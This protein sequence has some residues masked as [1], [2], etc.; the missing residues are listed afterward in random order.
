MSTEPLIRK[1]TH[2]FT[3]LVASQVCVAGL[4]EEVEKYYLA[5]KQEVA[6]AFKYGF[7]LPGTIP[8]P[9][10]PVEITGY[11]IE[12]TDC[13]AWLGHA[14]Q[15]T[16]KYLGMTVNLREMFALP[17]RLPW[18]HILPIFDPAGLTNWQMVEV[19]KAQNLIVWGGTDVGESTGA[20]AEGTTLSL[21]ERSPT[22]TPATM[23]LPPKYARH[24]F[25]GR[26][27]RPL[28]LRGYG[29]GQGLLYEVEKQFLDP[30]VTATVFPEN[31]FPVGGRVACGS[32]HAGDS[33][34]FF[35]RYDDDNEC[36]HCGFR[37]A[38]V[39]EEKRG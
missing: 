33:W 14:E 9:A 21:M 22:P 3:L 18:K 30:G 13:F 37:E 8:I 36:A 16:E 32:W 31:T 15:F 34:V 7:V 6:P 25:S 2:D 10:V 27:T 12:E 19:L 1:S 20:I 26:Q 4:T 11:P 38:I 5:Q 23:G 35:G 24:W 29:I 28:H 17:A 39:L